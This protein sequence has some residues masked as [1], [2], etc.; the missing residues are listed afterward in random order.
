MV[1]PL[2]PFY[3]A[4]LRPFRPCRIAALLG[5]YRTT[6]GSMVPSAVAGADPTRVAITSRSASSTLG[7]F[8]AAWA[9][10]AG[11]EQAVSGWSDFTRPEENI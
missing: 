3:P 1:T 10:R 7:L 6:D 5:G 8:C 9:T 4:S 11:F 2:R